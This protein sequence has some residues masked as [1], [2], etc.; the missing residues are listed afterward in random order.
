MQIGNRRV[1]GRRDG[2]DLHDLKAERLDHRPGYAAD[3]RGKRGGGQFGRRD[4]FPGGVIECRCGGAAGLRRGL[5]RRPC[6]PG[7]PLRG[8]R[9]GGLLRARGDHLQGALFR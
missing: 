3:R 1:L 9:V 6:G 2:D 5:D 7:A 8:Q 4:A